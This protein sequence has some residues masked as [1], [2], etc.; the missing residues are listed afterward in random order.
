MVELLKMYQTSIITIDDIGEVSYRDNLTITGKLNDGMG[1]LVPDQTLTI[2]IGDLVDTVITENG[3]F[4]YTIEVYQLGENTVT[5]TYEGTE[6][7]N[8]ANATTTFNVGK[9]ESKITIND[10]ATVTCNDNVTIKGS[11]SS[12][13]GIAL[14][15]VNVYIYYNGEEQHITTYKDGSFKT[16][17]KTST[18]GEQEVLVVYNGNK[19]YLASNATATFTTTSVK[20]ALYKINATYRDEYKVQGKLTDSEGN[21]VADAEIKITINDEV[22]TV[23]TD[24]NGKYLYTAKATKTGTITVTASYD[25]GDEFSQVSATKTVEVS[26][27]PVTL[28]VDEISDVAVGEEVKV[29]GKLSDLTGVVCKN[30]NI[31]VKINGVQQRILTDN[32]GVYTCTY[33]PTSAGTQNI[34][35]T[36]KGNV[37]YLGDEVTT[38]FEVTA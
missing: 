24:S 18:V 27:R 30:C 20:L 8:E 3:L 11:V 38:T 35:V 37:N 25:G 9:K 32:N 17:F 28:T 26:K 23:T 14:N 5:I 13:D 36:Y 29:T 33:T 31:F 22:V 1:N 21:A 10:I 19:K 12:V 6:N 7:H 15:N 2:T 16:T 34:T 4:E